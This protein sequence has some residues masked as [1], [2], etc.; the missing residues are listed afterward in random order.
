MLFV[1]SSEQIPHDRA[2]GSV[3]HNSDDNEASGGKGGRGQGQLQ[4]AVAARGHQRTSSEPAHATPAG[5]DNS[6]DMPSLAAATRALDLSHGGQGGAVNGNDAG[7]GSYW[8]SHQPGK[9]QT[10][11]RSG[12]MQGHRTQTPCEMGEGWAGA[13][14]TLA[15][16]KMQRVS[17]LG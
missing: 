5:H 3:M 6:G 15:V 12:L 9:L 16:R 7:G 10:P 17:I 14:T 8:E 11:P 13:T 4:R 1:P 2:H